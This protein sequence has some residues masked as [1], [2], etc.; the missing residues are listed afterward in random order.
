MFFYEP[1]NLAKVLTAGVRA[2][3]VVNVWSTTDQMH[4]DEVPGKEE[5]NARGT[6]ETKRAFRDELRHRPLLD[7]ANNEESGRQHKGIDDERMRKDV[8]S[9]R[10]PLAQQAEAEPCDADRAIPVA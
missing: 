2:G 5:G 7:N 8:L 9:K 3:A 1:I 10:P 6:P 4:S